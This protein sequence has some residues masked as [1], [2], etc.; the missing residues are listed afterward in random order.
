MLSSYHVKR[1]FTD[2]ANENA[3]FVIKIVQTFS[4]QETHKSGNSA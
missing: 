4:S 1:H 3:N 2:R